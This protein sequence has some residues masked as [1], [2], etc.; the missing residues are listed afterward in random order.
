MGVEPLI[1]SLPRQAPLSIHIHDMSCSGK[2]L[3]LLTRYSEDLEAST[4]CGK[5][6]TEGKNRHFEVRSAIGK[7]LESW[8][9]LYWTA[10]GWARW[11]QERA[12]G[13]EVELFHF[14]VKSFVERVKNA[15]E[16][17]H[18]HWFAKTDD[19]NK[20]KVTPTTGGS[21]RKSAR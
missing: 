6:I 13:A 15:L 19:W 4:S 12:E 7:S 17:G 9:R 21:Y 1:F 14:S 8:T 2:Q 3:E 16:N 10:G 11:C 18:M 20:K 5:K